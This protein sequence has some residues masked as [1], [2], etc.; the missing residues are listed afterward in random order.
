M[1]VAALSAAISSFAGLRSLASAAGW[2][3]PLAPL[4]PLT[5]DAYAIT[6][7][8]VWLTRD[9]GSAGGVRRF[10]RWNALL[11]MG[12]SLVG[13][14]LWHLAEVGMLTVGWPI[15]VGTGSVP[16][17]V[18]GLLSHLAVLRGQDGG[19]PGTTAVLSDPAGQNASESETIGDREAEE[20]LLTAARAAD[21][22][23]RETHDGRPIT[24]DALR[25]ELGVSTAR[26]GD[27]LRRMQRN[28]D[29]A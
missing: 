23:Y 24:R 4:L 16:P 11:A 6:A 15:V 19:P 2:P 29:E 20:P 7:T 22:R 9:T 26:A 21:V 14:G 12:L 27:V 10:A 1:T 5:V 13:N 17:V 28:R 3:E 25:R 8:R 18:L